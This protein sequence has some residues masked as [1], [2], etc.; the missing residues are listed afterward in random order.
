MYL[1]YAACVTFSS[2]FRNPLLLCT[3]MNEVGFNWLTTF[4]SILSSGL[5]YH[6]LLWLLLWS[7]VWNS[8]ERCFFFGLNGFSCYCNGM[9]FWF[10]LFDCCPFFRFV[11]PI[12][13]IFISKLL[14]VS[15]GS[16][17]A[18]A[19]ADG[20]LLEMEPPQDERG[21]FFACLCKGREKW[22]LPTDST[23]RH[24]T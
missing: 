1:I 10:C 21:I 3:Y 18:N 2:Y 13:P 14:I 9:L 12:E 22:C 11:A 8:T 23:T 7:G 24:N 16:Q 5:L 15:W 4:S 17:P 19:H 6:T 20:K